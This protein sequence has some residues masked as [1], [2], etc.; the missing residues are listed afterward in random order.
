VAVGSI[1]AARDTAKRLAAIARATPPK[2][3]TAHFAGCVERPR[4]SAWPGESS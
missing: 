4:E 1:R 2:S 3:R